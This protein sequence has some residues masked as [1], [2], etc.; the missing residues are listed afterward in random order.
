MTIRKLASIIAKKEG[1]KHQ[2]SIGDI[3]EI[4]GILSDITYD[5]YNYGYSKV[6]DV[7]YLNGYRRSKKKKSK[8]I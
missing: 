2:A 1:K 7:L 6:F 8:K 5:S 4:L 3:R